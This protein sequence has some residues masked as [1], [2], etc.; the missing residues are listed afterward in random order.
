MNS[1]G[2]SET[3]IYLT[4]IGVSALLVFAFLLTGSFWLTNVVM[5]LGCLHIARHFPSADAIVENDIALKYLRRFSPLIVVG[6]FL[7]M[8]ASRFI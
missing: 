3:P 8:V 6:I 5:V 1:S 7:F 2:P 4:I